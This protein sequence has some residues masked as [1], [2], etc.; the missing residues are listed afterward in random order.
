MM[1]CRNC[2]YNN[3]KTVETH[4]DRKRIEC[5]KCGIRSN[6]YTNPMAEM[7]DCIDAVSSGIDLEDFL[8]NINKEKE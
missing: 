8:L 6:I 3:Y 2:G 4:S 1:K 7:F 5:S